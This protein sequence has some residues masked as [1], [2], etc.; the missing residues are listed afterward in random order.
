MEVLQSRYGT[1]CKIVAD[2][3]ALYEMSDS[4]SLLKSVGCM[5]ESKLIYKM[6]FVSL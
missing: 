4:T 3:L 6:S 2:K 1:V 5:E